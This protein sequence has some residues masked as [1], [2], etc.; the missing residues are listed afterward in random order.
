M[1]ALLQRGRRVGA[2]RWSGGSKGGWRRWLALEKSL[3]WVRL[4]LLLLLLKVVMMML[5]VMM[6]VKM[7]KVVVMLQRYTVVT[8]P[9]FRGL[10]HSLKDPT[11]TTNTPLSLHQLC[12]GRA[13]LWLVRLLMM[14][15]GGARQ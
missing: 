13:V 4:K 8:Q 3:D 2:T 5:L 15:G 14:S 10:G 7:V 9:V 6:M 1:R 12:D 11:D